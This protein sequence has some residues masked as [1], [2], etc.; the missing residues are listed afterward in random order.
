MMRTARPTPNLP[1]SV[2]ESRPRT[3]TALK[4]HLPRRRLGPRK[5]SK[6]KK[7]KLMAKSRR[8]R[9]SQKRRKLVPRQRPSPRRSRVLVKPKLN[10]SATM[11]I[12]IPQRILRSRSLS[13]RRS[14]VLV[15][16]KLNPSATMPVRIPWRIQRSRSLPLRRSPR[17]LPRRLQPSKLQS[18][19]MRMRTMLTT[20]RSRSQRRKG[21]RR[22][23]L[24][25][26]YSADNSPWISDTF[27]RHVVSY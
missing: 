3:A 25:S 19:L 24:P 7:P 26:N 9:R 17:L 8:Q 13:S 4:V 18:S 6:L 10:L 22:S 12:Q 27:Y 14:R 21:E 16:P 23:P 20:S 1:R 15:K 11:P 5:L 2:A